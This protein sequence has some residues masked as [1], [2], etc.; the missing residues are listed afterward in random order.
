MP[1]LPF[2]EIK[3]RDGRIVS[4]DPKRITLAAYKALRAAGTANQKLAQTI[5]N[6]GKDSD[7]EVFFAREGME[8]EL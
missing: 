3:K 4:F 8:I 6:Q 5:C 1:T 2:E 7:M